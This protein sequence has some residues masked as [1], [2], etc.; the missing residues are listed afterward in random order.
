[1]IQIIEQDLF[2]SEA[3]LLIHQVNCQGVMG[4]GV[5]LQVATKY[6]HVEAEYLKYLRHCKKNK[7][8]PLGTVQ[9]VPTESWALVMSDTIQNKR[10]EK[11]D[12]NYQYIVNLFGQNDIGRGL[13]TDL[14]SLRKGFE[15]ILIKAQ[16][17]NAS[18][19]L[20][21]G[22]GSVRGGAN[23]NEVYKIIQDI[24]KN[25]NVDVTICK[26]NKG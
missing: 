5:A 9:Y 17:L 16:N 21:Y 20:P 1:M 13:Q 3:N 11:Y 26:C 10:L 18:I 12:K 22:L 2:N 19:A 4:S 24:F 23:W 8:N 6:P 7:L 15:D 14:H 25:T